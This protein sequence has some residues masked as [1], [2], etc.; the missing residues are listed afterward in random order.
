M[1]LKIEKL[2]RTANKALKGLIMTCYISTLFSLTMMSFQLATSASLNAVHTDENRVVLAAAA[3]FSIFMYLMRLY[4]LMNS[5]QVLGNRIKQSRMVLDD[6]IISH[7]MSSNLGEG[8]SNKFSI[9]KKRLEMYQFLHPI[10]PYTVLSLS[11]RTFCGTLATVL[12]YIIVLIKLNGM[13]ASNIPSLPN[14]S[15]ETLSV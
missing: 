3:I 9:L 10:T 15:N 6:N 8:C 12:T 4:I 14:S 7:G 1:G 11:S 5:G 2:V 13:G